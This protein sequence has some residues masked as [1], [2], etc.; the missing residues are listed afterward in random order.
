MTRLNNTVTRRATYRKGRNT[1]LLIGLLIGSVSGFIIGL[2]THGQANTCRGVQECLAV[3]LESYEFD[4]LPQ[5]EA[6]PMK[7]HHNNGE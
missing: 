5:W 3:H 7:P 2:T 1:G 4:Y 6:P